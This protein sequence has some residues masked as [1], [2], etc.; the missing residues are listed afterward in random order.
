[1][2]FCKTPCSFAWPLGRLDLCYK[3]EAIVV[4]M[5]VIFGL[6][7][8]DQVLGFQCGF[9]SV[10]D[11]ICEMALIYVWWKVVLPFPGPPSVVFSSRSYSIAQ[12]VHFLTT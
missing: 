7:A 8:P 3:F 2:L 5:S 9:F 4:Q 10:N 1:M 6:V 11:V 12:N